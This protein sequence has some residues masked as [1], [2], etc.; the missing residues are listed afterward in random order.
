MRRASLTRTSAPAGGIPPTVKVGVVIQCVV[1][2]KDTAAGAAA[3]AILEKW[4]RNKSPEMPAPWRMT[5]GNSGSEFGSVRWFEALKTAYGK[6]EAVPR[7]KL[8]QLALADHVVRAPVRC[9]VR[10]SH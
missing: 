5:A 8:W 7:F 9:G 1:Y 10:A 6:N 4:H 3:S 2:D